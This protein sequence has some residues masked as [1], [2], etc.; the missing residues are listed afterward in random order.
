M[1]AIQDLDLDNNRLLKALLELEPDL[2]LLGLKGKIGINA[3]GALIYIANYNG[4]TPII[5]T[6]KELLPGPEATDDPAYGLVTIDKDQ[7]NKDYISIN[8]TTLRSI[9]FDDGDISTESTWT[10]SKISELI[11]KTS[12]VSIIW[13]EPDPNPL[14]LDWINDPA[15]DITGNPVASG[16]T[17]AEVYGNN[18]SFDIWLEVAPGIYQP[19]L[20]VTPTI[21]MSTEVGEERVISNISID[22]S[23]L[24]SKIKI[25][26]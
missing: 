9:L 18:P 5:N 19:S 15:M 21:F 13:R 1:I 4:A 12:P 26:I 16:N 2:S 8:L 10:S 22:L 11:T 3:Q 25:T 6:I 7:D 20:S 24:K 23:G 17:W 14:L